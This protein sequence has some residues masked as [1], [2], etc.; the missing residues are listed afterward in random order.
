MEEGRFLEIL[1]GGTIPFA[2]VESINA[3]LIKLKRCMNVKLRTIKSKNGSPLDKYLRAL[4][5]KASEHLLL[6]KLIP[7]RKIKMWS[8]YHILR[9]K[10]T[11]CFMSNI[12]KK[13]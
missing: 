4:M 1:I 6:M 12:S 5:L 8:I 9:V 7:M 10:K 13:L 11:K 3:I 2:S